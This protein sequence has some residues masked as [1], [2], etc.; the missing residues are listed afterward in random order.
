MELRC[1]ADKE[2]EVVYIQE[3]KKVRAAPQQHQPQQ[4]QSAQ[5]QTQQSQSQPQ[6][7]MQHFPNSSSKNFS[8]RNSKHRYDNCKQDRRLHHNTRRHRRKRT[9]RAAVDAPRAVP[10]KNDRHSN[11]NNNRRNCLL[12]DHP[13]R[14]RRRR[15]CPSLRACRGGQRR[16]SPLKTRTSY[17]QSRFDR[18]SARKAAIPHPHQGPRSSSP[19][20]RRH[21]TVLHHPGTHAEHGGPEQAWHCPQYSERGCEWE[22]GDKDQGQ[23]QVINKGNNK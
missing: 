14:R 2:W 10:A 9:S 3:K 11:L 6:V 15:K 19:L 20:L 4:N 12:L 5:T 21:Q 17:I 7:P 1:S 18:S 23:G 16:H 13:S 22:E 8:R